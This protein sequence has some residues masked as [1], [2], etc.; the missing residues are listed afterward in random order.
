MHKPSIRCALL[1][2]M[3]ARHRWGSP[4]SKESLLAIAAIESHEYPR[5]RTEFDDLRTKPY[6]HSRGK[7]GIELDNGRFGALADLLYHECGW[8]AVEIRSRLK[9]Y[10]GWDEHDWA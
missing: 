7:R 4:I 5:A 1:A 8:S 10:E 3:I 6:V 2:A 9:H